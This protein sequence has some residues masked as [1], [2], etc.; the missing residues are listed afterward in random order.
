MHGHMNGI[1][2]IMADLNLGPSKM[3]D[4]TGDKAKLHNER[5]H[6]SCSLPNAITAM[7]W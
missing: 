4:V 6:C 5:L 7:E 1:V 2:C 3:E